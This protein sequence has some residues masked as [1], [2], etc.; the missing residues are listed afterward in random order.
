LSQNGRCGPRRPAFSADEDAQ[1]PQCVIKGTRFLFGIGIIL[2][3]FRGS[4]LD[5]YFGGV[6]SRSQFFRAKLN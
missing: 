4:L 6:D 3:Q 5:R 2:S 1:S